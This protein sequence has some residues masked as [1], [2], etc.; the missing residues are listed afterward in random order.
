MNT[1]S[2]V[3]VVTFL[4]TALAVGRPSFA[5][6]ISISDSWSEGTPTHIS[7]HL[8]TLT[9]ATTSTSNLGLVSPKSDPYTQTLNLNQAVTFILF[10]ADP[11]GSG[12]A[13]IPITFTLSDGT[14]SVTFTDWMNYYAN[15]GTD[16][17]DM[18]WSS[19]PASSPGKVNPP[20]TSLTQTVT[21]SDG[22]VFQLTLP[23]ETDWNM[24][25]QITLVWRDAPS[26]P[27]PASLALLST[28]LVG[29]GAAIRR[30]RSQERIRNILGRL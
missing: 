30:R 23:Y 16:F 7:N 29:F 12:A 8:P 11:N 25:Q 28:A 3:I 9:T 26:V 17:D 20:G 22:E 1:K 19:S 5:G 4:A 24:A 2:L 6:T 21:L 18:V 27:E 13:D 15:A 14:G 10:V